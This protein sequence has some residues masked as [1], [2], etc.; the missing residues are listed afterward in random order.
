MSRGIV[1]SGTD[2][3]LQIPADKEHAEKNAYQHSFE[4]PPPVVESDDGH[5]DELSTEEVA[6]ARGRMC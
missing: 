3:E 5:S 2:R 1:F 4:W 6:A